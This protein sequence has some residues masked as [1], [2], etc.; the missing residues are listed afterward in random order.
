MR[1]V[2]VKHSRHVDILD[3]TL[4]DGSYTIDYQF[5]ADETALIA[6][7]LER[8]EEL[9]RDERIHELQLSEPKSW[10]SGNP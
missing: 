8:F 2:M 10:I 1:E 5:T 9:R 3:T 7:G 6:Q 4:R